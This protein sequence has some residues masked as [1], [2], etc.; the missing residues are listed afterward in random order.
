M[1]YLS[2]N[3]LFINLN[4]SLLSI[5]EFQLQNSSLFTLVNLNLIL[6]AYL[7]YSRIG[8]TTKLNTLSLEHLHWL[9]RLLIILILSINNPN[10]KTLFILALNLRGNNPLMQLLQELLILRILI[11]SK[12]LLVTQHEPISKQSNLK[13]FRLALSLL[14]TPLL[15]TSSLLHGLLNNL[16][17]NTIS[18]IL[19]HKTRSLSS[20]ITLSILTLLLLIILLKVP[21]CPQVIHYK[22]QL[23]MPK[24]YNPNKIYFLSI[25]IIFPWFLAR[26][27]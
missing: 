15:G 6:R 24:N 16:I 12:D 4:L 27:S 7:L 26:P 25:I 21:K 18:V 1:S 17:L 20:H 2:K 23:K 10:I 3:S 19:D 22:S 5:G 9:R 14:L 8:L 13:L 11:G